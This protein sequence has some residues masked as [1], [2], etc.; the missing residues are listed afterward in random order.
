MKCYRCGSE[1]RITMV[2]GKAYCFQC[3]VDVSMEQYGLVRAI[4]EKRAS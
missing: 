2:K 1:Y 3:E 4:K